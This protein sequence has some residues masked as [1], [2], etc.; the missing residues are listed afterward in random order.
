MSFVVFNLSFRCGYVLQPEG[1]RSDTFELHT[2]D[3]SG[4]EPLTLTLTVNI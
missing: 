3:A 4:A 2:R 1:I